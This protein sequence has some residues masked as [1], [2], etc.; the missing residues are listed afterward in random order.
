MMKPILNLFDKVRP[1]IFLALLILGGVALAGVQLDNEVAM[2][3]AVGGII[4]LAMK[5]LENE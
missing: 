4:A 1:Q 2:G 3:T 5:V